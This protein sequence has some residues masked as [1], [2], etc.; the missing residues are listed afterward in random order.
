MANSTYVE[1]EGDDVQETKHKFSEICNSLSIE[2]NIEEIAWDDFNKIRRNVT[3][4]VDSFLLFYIFIYYLYIFS[5][6]I[7]GSILD[8]IL[9]I[10]FHLISISNFCHVFREMHYTG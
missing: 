4:E 10:F 3:L 9:F 6:V 8:K 2:S 1:N 5:I 7:L